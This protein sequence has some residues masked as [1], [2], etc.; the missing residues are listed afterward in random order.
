M[1][2]TI[3]PTPS[4]MGRLL[5]H[6]LGFVVEEFVHLGYRSVERHDLVARVGHIQDLSKSV[7]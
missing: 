4:G 6:T 7:S 2:R 1:A 5:N 3:R